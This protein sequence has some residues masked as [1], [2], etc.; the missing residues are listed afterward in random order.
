[1]LNRPMKG[2][3][4]KRDVVYELVKSEIGINHEKNSKSSTLIPNI[5]KVRVR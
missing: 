3:K 4:V 1:M 2:K 5:E